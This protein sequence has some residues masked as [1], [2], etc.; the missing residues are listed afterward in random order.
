MALYTLPSNNTGI[1]QIVIDTISVIPIFTPLL[2]AFVY[3]IVVLSGISMQVVRTGTADYPM[4]S[5]IG[6][7]AST[8]TALILSVSSGFVNLQWLIVSLTITIFSAVWL[9]LDKRQSE[10]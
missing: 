3:F 6:G 2:L 1:D 5:T 4:W 8:M 7:I 9:F 10:V